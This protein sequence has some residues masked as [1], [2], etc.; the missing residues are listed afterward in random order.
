MI[1]ALIALGIVAWVL[2][3]VTWWL[4]RPVVTETPDPD[5]SRGLRTDWS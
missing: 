4:E 3:W 1:V 5:R 2:L